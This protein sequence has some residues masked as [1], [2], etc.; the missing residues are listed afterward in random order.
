MIPWRRKWQPTPVSLPGKSHG[1]R[2]LVRCSPRGSK[3][4]G[5]TERL[6]HTFNILNLSKNNCI[7]LFF[8]VLSLHCCLGSSL[9]VV[10]RGRSLSCTAGASRCSGFSCTD[11][12]T[13]T[14]E[15][16]LQNM[17]SATVAPRVQS[18]GSVVV[19]HWSSCSAVIFYMGLYVHL[20][21]LGVKS[22][23]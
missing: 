18:T 4:S 22:I 17:G 7:C 14:S 8:A 1:Q 3:E 9:V 10:S 23:F 20:Y 2:S 15:H 11:F 12:R 5:I 6:T 19:A 13:W 21:T 16:G